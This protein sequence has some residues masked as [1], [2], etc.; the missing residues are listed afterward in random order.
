MTPL[1]VL[2]GRIRFEHRPLLGNTGGCSQLEGWIA[3]VDGV[4]EAA[5]N[6]RTGRIT[7]RFDERVTDARAVT[8]QVEGLLQ[9]VQFRATPGPETCRQGD[10]RKPAASALAGKAAVDLLAATVLPAPLKALLPLAV[11]VMG[12]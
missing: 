9:R 8:R 3:Q 6:P 12:R 2:P 10:G 11:H 4:V 5:V 1:T 7:V